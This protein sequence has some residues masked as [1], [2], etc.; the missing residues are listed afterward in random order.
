MFSLQ[1]PLEPD[2]GHISNLSCN[3]GGD[4]MTISGRNM[5]IYVQNLQ[6]ESMVK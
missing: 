2:P 4:L 1:N 5:C 6:W 3:F